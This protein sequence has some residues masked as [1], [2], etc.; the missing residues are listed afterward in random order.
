MAERQIAAEREIGAPAERVYGYIADYRDHHHKF[1]PPAFFDYRVEE[2]GIGAGTVIRFRLKVGGQVR[3]YHQR[4]TEPEPGRVITEAAVE[5][6]G[7][8]SFTVTPRGERCHL[9]I[10]TTWEGRGGLLGRVEQFMASRLLLPL[11]RDELE[12]IDRYAR[13]QAG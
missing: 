7:A 10:V 1:L 8:T 4:I 13:E 12:R 6:D 11:Y 3:D 9:R 5:G 2:G